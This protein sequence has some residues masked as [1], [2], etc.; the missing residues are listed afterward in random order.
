MEQRKPCFYLST[1]SLGTIVYVL[2]IA[3]MHYGWVVCVSQ[4]V[5]IVACIALVAIPFLLLSIVF[6]IENIRVKATLIVM[7]IPAVL[8]SLMLVI[9]IGLWAYFSGGDNQRAEMRRY[10]LPSSQ[11]VLYHYNTGVL[12][13]DWLALRQEKE[14][15]PGILLVKRLYDIADANDMTII[16]LNDT[17]IRVQAPPYSYIRRSNREDVTINVKPSVYF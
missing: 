11:L 2:G 8:M 1:L 12:G 7:L 14:V 9:F 17:T 5:N 4:A 10:R 13:H 3:N 6:S 16:L 15:L